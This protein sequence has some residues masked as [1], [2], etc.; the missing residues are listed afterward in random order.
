MSQQP[1]EVASTAIVI[2][3]SDTGVLFPRTLDAQYRY[4]NYLVASGLL[5]AGLNTPAKALV[6]M[7]FLYEVGLPLI[8]S[9][10]KICVINGVVSM[11]GDLPLALAERSGKL[12]DFEE[13]WIDENGDKLNPKDPKKK[14]YGAACIAK[15]KGRKTAVDRFFTIED[16]TTAKLWGKQSGGKDSPWT[17]YPKRMLQMRTRSWALK[18]CVPDA[19]YGISIAEYDHNVLVDERGNVVGAEREVQTFSSDVNKAFLTK[20]SDEEEKVDRSG[21][22]KSGQGDPLPDMQEAVGSSPHQE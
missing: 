12:E 7:Q 1:I 19:L 11:F 13:W 6:G 16:A 18:D 22:V 10:G 4:A 3:S 9:I 20:V 15:R 21:G 5:P 17:L 14:L 8:A 2:E